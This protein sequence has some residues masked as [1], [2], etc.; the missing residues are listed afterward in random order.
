MMKE[1]MSSNL[2]NMPLYVLSLLLGEVQMTKD[3]IQELKKEVYNYD[4]D[5]FD[6][7]CVKEFNENFYLPYNNIFSSLIK[8]IEK[9]FNEFD[10]KRWLSI[11]TFWAYIMK[12]NASINLHNHVPRIGS[13]DD[14]NICGTFY[15]DVPENSGNINFV[16]NETGTNVKREHNFLPTNNMVIFYPPNL[17]HYVSKNL[18]DKDRISFSFN[19]ACTLTDQSYKK[20]MKEG[21]KEYKTKIPVVESNNL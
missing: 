19:G 4:N 20:I 21:F 9:A 7:S 15:I 11:Q 5:D 17:D 2:K 13:T 14:W 8:K 1:N 6:F 3:E 12:P 10:D 16:W 18:S